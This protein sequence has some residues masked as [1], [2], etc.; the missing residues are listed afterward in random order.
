MYSLIGNIGIVTQD[1]DSINGTGQIKVKGELWSAIGK[2]NI[3]ISKGS[4]VT[5]EEIQGVKAIVTPINE[6]SKIN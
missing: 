4:K 1:I 6:T 5:I 2:D 3:N